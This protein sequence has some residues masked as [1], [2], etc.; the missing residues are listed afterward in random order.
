M[1]YLKLQ[2]KNYG[3]MITIG[4]YIKITDPV[5]YDR[6]IT[7]MAIEIIQKI[8]AWKRL[9][10]ITNLVLAA[11]DVSGVDKHYQYI[12]QERPRPGRGGLLP[13]EG[14]DAL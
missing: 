5:I 3:V 14:D 11:A 6:L 1:K 8:E 7:F 2:R 13:G 10:D 9:S 4:E 12:M